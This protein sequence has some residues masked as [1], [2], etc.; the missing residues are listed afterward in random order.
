[1]KHINGKNCPITFLSRE[2][3]DEGYISHPFAKEGG[4]L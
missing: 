2:K 1:V 4:G 3:G